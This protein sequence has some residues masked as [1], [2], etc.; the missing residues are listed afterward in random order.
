MDNLYNPLFEA[1]TEKYGLPPGLLRS[2]QRLETGSMEGAESA[3]GPETSIGRA[4]GLMQIMPG[5]ARAYKGNP[6]VPKEAVDI[7]ARLTRDNL[8]ALRKAFPDLSDSELARMAVATYHSGI[9]NIMKAKGIP[10][11]PAV[12][13]YIKRYDEMRPQAAEEPPPKVNPLYAEEMAAAASN[14]PAVAAQPSKAEEKIKVPPAPRNPNLDPKSL[15]F[16]MELFNSVPKAPESF[17]SDSYL[18]AMR[19]G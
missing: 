4:Q 7:A 18:A 8:E 3:E 5:I 6:L 16:L 12:Q 11:K 9:G 13:A 17:F 10:D 15:K 1:A 14:I 2:I 19:R